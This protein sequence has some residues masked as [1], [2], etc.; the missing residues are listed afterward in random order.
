MCFINLKDLYTTHHNLLGICHQLKICHFYGTLNLYGDL[1]LVCLRLL[2]N[3]LPSTKEHH[4][5][6][7]NLWHEF[8]C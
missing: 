8:E 4:I 6:G 3:G 7:S 2:W 5:W 1:K